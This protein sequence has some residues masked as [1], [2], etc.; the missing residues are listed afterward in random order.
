MSFAQR[1][2]LMPVESGPTPY[3]RQEPIY[4]NNANAIS[5]IS[6]PVINNPS[7]GEVLQYNATLSGLV[8]GAGGGGGGGTGF[9]GPTGPQGSNGSTGPTGAIGPTGPAGGGGGGT[10]FTGPTGAIG[11]TGPAGSGGGGNINL[12]GTYYSD[13]IYWNSYSGAWAV[14]SDTVHLGRDAGYTG[15][16]FDAIAIGSNAGRL[17]QQSNAIS[18]GI[19]SGFNTQGTNS[20]AIGNQA[21]YSIQQES[22]IAIGLGAG[23]AT[24]GT[25]SIAIGFQSGN[26]NQGIYSI[27]LG[28][29]AGINAQADFSIV[30]NASDTVVLDTSASGFYVNPVNSQPSS[31]YVL[32]YDPVSYEIGYVPSGGG[33]VGPTGSTGPAGTPGGPTGPTGPQGIQGPTGPSNGGGGLNVTGAFWG[34]Y[35]Y[36]NNSTNQWV[37]GSS[38]ITLGQNAGATSQQTGAVALGNQAG[39][40]IQGTGSVAIGL[41]SGFTGQGEYSV[42]IGYNAGPTGQASNSIAINA[43][44]NAFTPGSSGFFVN[45]INSYTGTNTSYQALSYNTSTSEIVRNNGVLIKAY[46]SFT[47]TNGAGTTSSIQSSY[48]ISSITRNANPNV[49]TIQYTVAFSNALPDAF[50]AVL[51]SGTNSGDTAANANNP[52]G[53]SYTSRTTTGF[54]MYNGGMSSVYSGYPPANVSFAVIR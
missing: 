39:R 10:G 22:A 19:D 6:I 45:P 12:T 25:G 52:I 17:N 20:I 8:W 11:P 3:V 9:T 30:L 42:A 2:A 27:A 53:F 4:Q 43:S 23:Y 7:D 41:R 29:N 13:Y 18:M 34:D 37:V 50:Y 54:I 15:Q 16:G 51:G 35:L 40:Y 49:Y 24:Q 36:W 38:N 28:A 47:G 14:G 1:R 48:N 44:V 26:I 33:S 31:T 5:V 32:S 46:A 21:G